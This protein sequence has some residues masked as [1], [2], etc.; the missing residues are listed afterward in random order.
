M[1]HTTMRLVLFALSTSTL[2]TIC[3]AAPAEDAPEI[4]WHA[5]FFSGG[6]DC[7]EAIAFVQAIEQVGSHPLSIVQ[8]GDGYSEEFVRGMPAET[9]RDLQR[10]AKRRLRRPHTSVAVCHSEPGAWHPSS[11]ASLCP[12]RG[13]GHRVGR[14]MFETDRLPEGWNRRLN[15]MDQV[16]VPTEFARRVFEA[17][18]VT[19]SRLRVIGEPVDVEFFDPGRVAAPLALPMLGGREQQE[20]VF[21]SVFKW[22]ER[23]G[24]DVL[25][26][27][28]YREFTAAEGVALLILTNAYHAAE[29]FEIR[30]VNF[31]GGLEGLGP[32]EAWPRV[33]FHPRVA[34]TDL[35]ALYAAVGAFVLPS[36][37]EGWG[38]PHVEAMAMGL[39]VIATNWSGP[40]EYLTEANGY[41]LAVEPNLVPVREGAFKGH[42]W[43]QPSV[44]HLRQ[45]LRRVLT[46]RDEARAKGEQARRDMVER[47]SPQVLGAR[48]QELVGELAA[49]SMEGA[50]EL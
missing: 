50:A 37:G 47:F 38:R 25:L 10:L 49:S 39:P 32:R 34:Q 1:L 6:G 16:W 8:H 35:P 18:G 3:L 4:N 9:R 11:W 45:L 7:S 42:L 46:H 12:P 21:L 48:I 13:A 40:T 22:E 43:A 30:A 28:F 14:T 33:A 26:E 2:V 19:P 23:K 41:P 44:A 31:A 29:D 36:R 27:A 24:W 15:G 5:P 17:G 20:L